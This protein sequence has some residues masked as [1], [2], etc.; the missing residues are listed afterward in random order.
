MVRKVLQERQFYQL[1][2]VK[3]ERIIEILKEDYENPI[4]AE[5]KSHFIAYTIFEN[6]IISI[7]KEDRP[8]YIKENVSVIIGFYKEFQN[9]IEDLLMLNPEFDMICFMGTQRSIDI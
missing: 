9:R 5:L 3:I 8:Q 7:D 1:K 2:G 4:L 6:A